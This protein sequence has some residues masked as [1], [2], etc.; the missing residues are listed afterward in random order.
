GTEVRKCPWSSVV[1]DATSPFSFSTTKAAFA[2]GCEPGASA[3]VGPGWAGLIVITPSKPVSAP[4]GSCPAEIKTAIIT[5]ARVIGNLRNR[6]RKYSFAKWYRSKDLGTATGSIAKQKIGCPRMTRINANGII[7][8]CL[9]IRVYS[10]D[11]R[12][13]LLLLRVHSCS[14]VVKPGADLTIQ[15]LRRK[16]SA[17]LS[18]ETLSAFYYCWWDRIGHAG[19]RSDALSGKA[20][21]ASH[22]SRR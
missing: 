17:R 11:S 18:H 4:D 19:E 20:T 15:S 13:N 1:N 5:N 21:A 9:Y 7:S 2:S 3:L 12:A 8:T 6:I 10:R 14:F 22:Y 16:F